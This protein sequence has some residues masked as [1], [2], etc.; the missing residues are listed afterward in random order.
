MPQLSVKYHP[1]LFDLILST[2]DDATL[3]AFRATSRA[4]RAFLDSRLT[5]HLVQ[6]SDPDRRHTYRARLWSGAWDSGTSVDVLDVRGGTGGLESAPGY[7]QGAGL[8]RVFAGRGGQGGTCRLPSRRALIV[9][10]VDGPTTVDLDSAPIHDEDG[11][12]D[13]GDGEPRIILNFAYR[14][15]VFPDVSVSRV[16]G[17]GGG[18]ETGGAQRSVCVVMFTSPDAHGGAMRLRD[19]RGFLGLLQFMDDFAR[20][21]P[22]DGAGP[23]MSFIFIGTEAFA[24]HLDDVGVDSLDP[25][26]TFDA[27]AWVRDVRALREERKGTPDFQLM[28]EAGLSRFYSPED[29]DVYN[30]V[31]DHVFYDTAQGFRNRYREEHA[32]LIMDAGAPHGALLLSS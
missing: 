20:R 13:G 28:V 4:H 24:F 27:E 31:L 14:D 1:H 11:G 16:R 10:H 19:A 3:R 2:A 6:T 18:G 8:V 17:G 29:A 7:W 22:G 32:E 15:N 23:P 25:D 30:D 26:L 9:L 21:T 5:R 12:E